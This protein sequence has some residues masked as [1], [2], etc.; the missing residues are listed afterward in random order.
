MN[1]Y[2]YLVRT[3]NR[4]VKILSVFRNQPA[5][6]ATQITDIT[7]LHL[8]Q[9]FTVTLSNTI[10]QYQPGW[11]TWIETANNTDELKANLAKRKITG[12]YFTTP[13]CPFEYD[14]NYSPSLPNLKTVKPEYKTMVQKITFS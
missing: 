2:L 10:S 11:N 13:L 1:L 9:T 4:K 3:D 7:I 14:A 5:Y 8:P 12:L 6:P